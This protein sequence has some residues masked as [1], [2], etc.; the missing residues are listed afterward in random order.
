MVAS[1]LEVLVFF[2]DVMNGKKEEE[3]FTAKERMVAA[4]RL[5][6]IKGL[7][8]EKLIHEHHNSGKVE[9]VVRLTDFAAEPTKRELESN[10]QLR[11]EY[12][13]MLKDKAAKA[14]FEL[15]PSESV[16]DVDLSLEDIL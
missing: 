14:G 5:A 7:L 1:S 9:H 15:V 10:E 13:E 3:G 6:K 2:T 16:V 4:D 12:Q 11:I 8:N